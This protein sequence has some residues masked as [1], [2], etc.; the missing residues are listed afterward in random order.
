[1]SR[2]LRNRHVVAI[3]M[4]GCAVFLAPAATNAAK[5]TLING[6]SKRRGWCALRRGQGGPGRFF[7]LACQMS[8]EFPV[9]APLDR[10]RRGGRY[11]G[12]ASSNTTPQ[13]ATAT[14]GLQVGSMRTP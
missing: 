3:V 10:W 5:L 13:R 2:V 9:L 14:G 1:M 4:A 8:G 12:I 11:C 7:Y 6:W